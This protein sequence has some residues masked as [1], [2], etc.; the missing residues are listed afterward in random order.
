MSLNKSLSSCHNPHRE[1]YSLRQAG[2]I[3]WKEPDTFWYAKA[4]W[5]AF[6]AN[7][8]ECNH[9]EPKPPLWAPAYPRR[10]LREHTQ[11]LVSASLAF[12]SSSRT[13]ILDRVGTLPSNNRLSRGTLQRVT[14]SYWTTTS[15]FDH[16]SRHIPLLRCRKGDVHWHYLRT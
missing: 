7:G 9:S 5:I 3:F 15:C 10:I 1:I 8:S 11:S 2:A 6:R 12:T 16:E 13:P 4:P 14:L